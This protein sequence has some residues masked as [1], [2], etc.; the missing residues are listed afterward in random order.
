MKIPL[1]VLARPYFKMCPVCG[2]HGSIV[3]P[4]ME[5][6]SP[7]AYSRQDALELLSSCSWNDLVMPKEVPYLRDEIFDSPLP[8]TA[9]LAVMAFAVE[10]CQDMNMLLGGVHKAFRKYEEERFLKKARV[11]SVY[12]H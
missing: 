5:W 2:R 3:D 4:E 6:I 12:K 9:P 11:T 7:E 10:T 8:E 1:D